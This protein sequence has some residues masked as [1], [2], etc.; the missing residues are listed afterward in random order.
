M[1]PFPDVESVLLLDNCRI[2]HTDAL[3]DVLN[4]AGVCDH[5]IC[6]ETISLT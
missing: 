4:D 3:Q 2:H 1:N 5:D 6:T